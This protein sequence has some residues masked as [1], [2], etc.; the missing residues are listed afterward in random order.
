MVDVRHEFHELLLCF[1][2]DKRLSDDLA[3]SLGWFAWV[4][5]GVIPY[6]LID[7]GRKLVYADT[8]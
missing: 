1:S 8:G 6:K 5:S 3:Q 4:G 7:I 2:T